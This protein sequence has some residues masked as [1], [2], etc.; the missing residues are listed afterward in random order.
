[1]EVL[2]MR[3]VIKDTPLMELTLRRYEK[4]STRDIRELLKKFCLSMGLLQPGDSRDIIVDI[5]YVLLRAKKGRLD[6]ES[7]DIREQVV[8]VRKERNLPLLG[9]ASSN[10]RRQIKRLRDMLIVEKVKNSYRI[11]EFARLSDT[12]DEKI[13][14]YV[15]PTITSRVKEYC[16]VID[17]E[18]T[19]A[20]A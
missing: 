13:G 20:Q 2:V 9:V 6:L 8:A 5:L 12:F 18:F 15:L 14:K 11:T 3:K 19:Q 7:E 10:V 17:D 16:K 1:M 4:P